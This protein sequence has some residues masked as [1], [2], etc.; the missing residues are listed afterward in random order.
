MQNRM[1]RSSGFAAWLEQQKA[2]ENEGEPQETVSIF[3]QFGAI[4]DSFTNQLQEMSGVLPEAG[5]MSSAFRARMVQAI[6][7]L[8][9]SGAFALLTVF[10]GLPTLL[11]RPTKFVI[12]LSLSTLL[13]ASSVVVMQKPSVFMAG[14]VAG[15][16][17]KSGPVALLAMSMLFTLYISIFVHRYMAVIFA[18][19]VQLLCLLF[20]LAFFIPGGTAGVVVL[21]KTTYLVVRTAAKPAFYVGKKACIAGLSR[22]F[23]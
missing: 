8:A 18:A 10:V 23:T 21:L 4:Q 7:L 17:E 15:G 22:I 13:A 9:A 1:N 19:G 2:V 11:V 6:Y 5:A 3:S 12:C 20:Y 14:L 16:V